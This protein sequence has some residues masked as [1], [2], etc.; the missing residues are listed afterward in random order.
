MSIPAATRECIDGLSSLTE[1]SGQ[2]DEGVSATA[3]TCR[4]WAQDQ[5]A[6]LNLWAVHLDVFARGRLNV[7]YRLRYHEELAKVILHV[8]EDLRENIEWLKT[9]GMPRARAVS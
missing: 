2:D 5:S 6:R 1:G 7:E 9:M 8:L 4:A 3:A